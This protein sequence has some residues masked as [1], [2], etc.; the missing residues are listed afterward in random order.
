MTT[1]YGIIEDRWGKFFDKVF[2]ARQRGDYTSMVTFEP[3]Q[4]EDFLQQAEHF[5]K[6]MERLITG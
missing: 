1:E 5:L 3:D 4:L 2:E 6:E